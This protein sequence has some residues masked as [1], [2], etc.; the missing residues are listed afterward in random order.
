MTV[1]PRR[2]KSPT[3]SWAALCSSQPLLPGSHGLG[4]GPGGGGVR[5]L[6]KYSFAIS[7]PDVVPN[8]VLKYLP[9]QT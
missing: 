7:G 9:Q 3:A 2:S 4:V 8:V 1:G 6:G 5:P